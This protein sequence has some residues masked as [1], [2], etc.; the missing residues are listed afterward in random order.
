MILPYRA[1]HAEA[2]RLKMCGDLG[3]VLFQPFH[4]MDDASIRKAVQYS[5]VVINLVGRDWETKNFPFQEVHV[6][7]ARRLAR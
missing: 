2:I 4:L 5:N 1:D 3:Q 6:D 7:S